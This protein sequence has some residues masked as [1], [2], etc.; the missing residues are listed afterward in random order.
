MEAKNSLKKKP[1]RP[2]GGKGDKGGIP[3]VH[4]GGKPTLGPLPVGGVSKAKTKKPR[5][6]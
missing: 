6:K 4:I 5:A 1:G 2:K 3:K